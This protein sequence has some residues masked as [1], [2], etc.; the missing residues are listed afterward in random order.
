M[1]PICCC[2]LWVPVDVHTAQ[3]RI[4]MILH[5]DQIGLPDVQGVDMHAA[6]QRSWFIMQ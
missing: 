1:E 4:W 3:K 2:I 5:C 6:R